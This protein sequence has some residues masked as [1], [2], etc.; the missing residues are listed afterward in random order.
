MR[1]GLVSYLQQN[2]EAALSTLEP[3]VDLREEPARE[4]IPERMIRVELAPQASAVNRKTKRRLERPRVRRP[5]MRRVKHR[6]AK[7]VVAP[8]R[9]EH[10]RPPPAILHLEREPPAPDVCSHSGHE[11]S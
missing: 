3:L 2:Y 5:K 7:R 6:P 1:L 9:P 4:R 10:E 8:N 11:S